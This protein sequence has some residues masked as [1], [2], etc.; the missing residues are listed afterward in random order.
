MVEFFAG[1]LI[2]GVVDSNF[3]GQAL[4][5]AQLAIASLLIWAVASKFYY[6]WKTQKLTR[7]LVRDVM[8]GRGV[9][10]YY[11]ARHDSSHSAVENIYSA[12]CDRLLR[13]FSPEVRTGLI[14]RHS[15]AMAG[16]ALSKY[17]MGLVTSMC[18]HRLDEEEVKVEKGMGLISMIVA[19]EPMIGLLGTVWGVLD[20]FADMGAAGS[21][22]IA[23]MAPAI[24]AALVTTVVGL[25]VAIPGIGLHLG[26][27]WMVR[28]IEVALEGFVDDLTGRIEFEF[29]GRDD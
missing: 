4:V 1:S 8:G 15:E 20:A 2:Q 10:E 23:T 6:L 13:L 18:E 7:R 9:L 21:A 29:R 14:A 17:E 11:V 26:L 3:M 27:S 12:T 25:L 22:T 16:A 5:Y 24:S 28:Q 19:I